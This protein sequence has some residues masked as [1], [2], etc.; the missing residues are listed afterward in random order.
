M[1]ADTPC[2]FGEIRS[3]R[4]LPERRCAFVNY[5]HKEAAEAAYAAMQVRGAP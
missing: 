5:A 1:G 2:R 4:L 3:L